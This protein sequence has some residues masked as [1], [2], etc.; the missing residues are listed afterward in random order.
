MPE[1]SGWALLLARLQVEVGDAAGASR[2]LDAILPQAK[3][4]ADYHAFAGTVLQMQGRRAEAVASY[5]VAVRLAPDSAKALTGLAI[6]LEDGGRLPEA[7]EA[8]QRALSTGALGPELQAFVE[9]K[10]AQLK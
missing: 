10:I 9:R 1:N 4:N 6:A 3:N 5:E 7:R 8:Y 2:T